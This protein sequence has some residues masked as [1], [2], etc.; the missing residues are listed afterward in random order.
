[1]S[2]QNPIAEF[3]SLEAASKAATYRER[4]R[5]ASELFAAVADGKEIEYR[6]PMGWSDIEMNGLFVN[7][8]YR[9]ADWW[10]WRINPGSEPTPEPH[11]AMTRDQL[12]AEAQKDKNEEV[13]LL[14]RYRGRQKWEDHGKITRKQAL[15]EIDRVGIFGPK[16]YVILPA[17]EEGGAA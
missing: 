8:T 10:R 11:P 5:H 3:Q 15:F 16:E 17:N 9:H 4:A 1:M 6:Y 12:L 13:I 14:A 2:E 7:S